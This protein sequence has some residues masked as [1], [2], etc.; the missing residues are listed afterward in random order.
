MANFDKITIGEQTVDVNDKRFTKTSTAVANMIGTTTV[1]AIINALNDTESKQCTPI[2][3]NRERYIRYQGGTA[4]LKPSQTAAMTFTYTG[5]TPSTSNLILKASKP[6][7]RARCSIS[8]SGNTIGVTI[9][10]MQLSDNGTVFQV[11]DPQYNVE[12]DITPPLIVSSKNPTFNTDVILENGLVSIICTAKA[13]IPQSV[14][15]QLLKDDSALDV[16][17]HYTVINNESVWFFVYNCSESEFL[18]AS[19]FKVKAMGKVQATIE[20]DNYRNS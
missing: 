4:G 5:F 8:V 7:D 13:V 16:D 9:W 14:G 11:A 20:T 18:A 2:A 10:E 3:D 17:I 19:T 1:G 12:S 6:I 15:L